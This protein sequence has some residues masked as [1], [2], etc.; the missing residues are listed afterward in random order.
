MQPGE[1]L[2]RV[3]FRH[4]AVFLESKGPMQLRTV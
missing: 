3:Y 1:K 4:V 2:V